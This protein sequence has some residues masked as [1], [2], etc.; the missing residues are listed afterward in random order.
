MFSVGGG[1]PRAAVRIFVLTIAAVLSGYVRAQDF[2]VL[3]GQ[4]VGPQTMA[5]AGDTGVV[6]AGGTIST[7]GAPG[8]RMLA[9][10]Q[11][12]ANFGLI[13]TT[14][15]F[16]YGIRSDALGAQIGNTGTIATA[17]SDAHGILSM[18]FGATIVNSGNITTTGV[19]ARGILSVEDN[20]TIINSGAIATTALGAAGIASSGRDAVIANS[21]HIATNGLGA[22]GIY[23]SFLN[24]TIN[25]S[26]SIT[27]AGPSA[28]GIFVADLDAVVT[29]S[30]S[31][32]AAQGDAIQFLSGSATLNLLAGTRI[33]GGIVFSGAGNTVTF[34]PGL[35]AL[36]TFA[37]AG[38]PGTVTTAGNPFAISG[39]S[40]AVL[41]RSGFVLAED[42]A[43]SAIGDLGR[44]GGRGS[45]IGGTSVRDCAAEAWLT[46]FGGVGATPAAADLAGRQRGHGG[47]LAGIDFTPGDGLTAGIFMGAL[48][49]RGVVVLS[50]DSELRGAAVGGHVAFSMDGHFVDL[51]LMGGG[52][53]FRSQRTVADNTVAGGL[54]HASATYGGSF[55]TP[56]LTLGTN[57]ETPQGTLTP[58][59]GLRYTGLML[60]G[61][62]ESGTSDGLVVN[63]R[64][65][66][67]LDLQ[68]QLALALTP[69]LTEHG[70]ISTT[71]RLGADVSHREGGV[72][73]GTLLGQKVSFKS[74][75]G[76]SYRGFAAFE[77]DY[78]LLDGPQLFGG[79]EFG[80]D[81]SGGYAASARGGIRGSF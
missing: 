7:S 75:D 54:D 60:D 17:G 39:N 30:G 52:L 44:I 66:H 6:E 27:T 22:H 73:T 58:S 35:N 11:T 77:L 49:G 40:I 5:G 31:I 16:S 59:L 4:T 68:A 67:Q 45:C 51:S 76:T 41:D 28:R 38:M 9:D 70:V 34:G 37:G 36:T 26:G 48:A 12:A 74:G 57:L 72:V 23:A 69:Q 29:N 10:D 50:Q 65:V 42:M 2:T 19:L 18:G 56:A 80:I 53:Q 79:L 20:A 3:S 55:I 32:T 61:F 13:R 25:N 46:G 81:T 21:G 33:E 1:P 24:P 43:L 14:G 63:G 78:A 64:A 15:S 62:A 71:V 47:L 8:V